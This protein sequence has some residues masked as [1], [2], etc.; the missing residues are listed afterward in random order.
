MDELR[1]IAV[2]ELDRRDVHRNPQRIGPRRGFLTG[3]T[4]DPFAER[5]DLRALFGDRNKGL[6]RY[7]AAFRAV[8]ACQASKPMTLPK[9]MVFCG[10]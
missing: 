9:A 1:Q 3:L 6:G 4:Q 10:W 7:P 8:P 5:N 2:M